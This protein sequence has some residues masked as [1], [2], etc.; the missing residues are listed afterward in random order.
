MRRLHAYGT[1]ILARRAA[2]YG[3]MAFV[4]TSAWTPLVGNAAPNVP[5]HWLPVPSNF[6]TETDPERVAEISR[7]YRYGAGTPLV[8]HFGSFRMRDSRQF[9]IEAIPKICATARERHVLLLGRGSDGFATSLLNER[10][11]LAGRVLGVGG[12]DSQDLANHLGACDILIQPYSDGATTRRGSLLAGLALG[13]P[14][15]T[16]FGPLTE[17]FWLKSDAALFAPANDV[18]ATLAVLEGALA[19][20]A[21]RRRVGRNARDLYMSRFDLAHTIK[22][23][24]SR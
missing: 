7:Q 20:P 23:L 3:D 9:L 5:I 11:E 18:D 4:S 14:A 2:T 8:G 24:R 10:P 6:R 21:L 12:L 22:D 15:V 16:S 1:R 17:E 19:D 13:I